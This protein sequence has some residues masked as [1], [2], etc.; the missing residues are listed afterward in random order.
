MWS[1]RLRSSALWC[2]RLSACN[3]KSHRAFS[4][5]AQPQRD[6]GCPIASVQPAQT[7]L[8]LSF[9]NVCSCVF[10]SNTV[11]YTNLSSPPPQCNN[12]VKLGGQPFSGHGCPSVPLRDAEGELREVLGTLLCSS[13]PSS[14]NSLSQP[15]KTTPTPS[16]LK[17]KGHRK[18]CILR[19]MFELFQNNILQ[20]DPPESI[21]NHNPA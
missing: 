6:G 14:S 21:R 19:A 4:L 8:L 16:Q 9:M 5:A 7:A 20:T 12:T 17:F 18:S 10:H 11:I 3:N 13:F 2:A 15:Q 1:L